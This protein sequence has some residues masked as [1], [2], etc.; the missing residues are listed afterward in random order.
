AT[1]ATIALD[2]TGSADYQVSHLSILDSPED[3]SIGGSLASQV[4]YSG[5]ASNNLWFYLGELNSLGF[6]NP[7][8]V[9]NFAS[10]FDNPFGPIRGVNPFNPSVTSPTLQQVA[11]VILAPQVVYDITAA[12]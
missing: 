12:G 11:D 2:R 3:N 9:D 1:V 10:Y 6:P 4:V 5:D 8:F 7:T